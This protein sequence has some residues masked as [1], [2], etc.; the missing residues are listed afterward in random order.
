MTSTPSA[1]TRND[2]QGF[3]EELLAASIKSRSEPAWLVERRRKAFEHFGSAVM[4]N[5][6]DEDWRRT[7]IRAL[8][9]GSFAPPA[10]G[11]E[12]SAAATAALTPQWDTLNAHYGTGLSHV[13]GQVSSRP[14]GEVKL[15]AGVVFT[16]LAEAARSHPEILER[17]L[18]TKAVLPG[19]DL[20]SALHAA[21]WTS[22]LLLYVPRGVKVA[23]PLFHLIGLS[24]AGPC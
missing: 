17:Y 22:G 14:G 2:Q 23:E 7:D 21:F 10:A 3:T 1:S 5:L 20:F 8:K 12:A 4:P 19:E 24:A 16:T 13:D 9:L 11:G 6:R 15:P 18:S